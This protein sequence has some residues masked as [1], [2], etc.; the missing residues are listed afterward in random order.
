[1]LSVLQGAALLGGVNALHTAFP[2][3]PEEEYK[4]QGIG[5]VTLHDLLVTL[6]ALSYY[7]L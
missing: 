2:E 3:D 5:E 1:M 7:P 6:F 4:V